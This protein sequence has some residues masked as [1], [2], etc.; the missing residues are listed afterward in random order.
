MAKT[1]VKLEF[2]RELREACILADLFTEAKMVDQITREI[3]CSF[4]F[5]D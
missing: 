5:R 3:I 1:I 4:G 2:L